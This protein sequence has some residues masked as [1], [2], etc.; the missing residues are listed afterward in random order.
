MITIDSKLNN[1]T[2]KV[3]L[4]KDYIDR[5]KYL[6]S[7]IN[8]IDKIRESKI[9]ALD[10]DWGSGKTWFVKSLEYLMNE[11]IDFK[12]NNIDID[13]LNSVKDNYMTFY[14]NAWENDDAQSAML[15]LMYK[16]VNDSCM[17]KDKDSKGPIP[18]ILNTVIKYATAGAVD[19]KNDL[20]GEQWTNKQITD[21]IKTSEKIKES[22]KELIDS[23]LVENKNKILI[24]IDEIDRCKPT[25]AINL[26]ENIKHFYDD[27]RI[28]FL[29]ATNNKQLGATVCKVYGEKYDGNLYLDK[30]FDLTLELPNNYLEKYISAIDGNKSNSHY[31]YKVPRELAKEYSIS[32]RE[33][34]RYL[35]SI[36]II[37]KYF[38]RGSDIYYIGVTVKY[39]IIPI[40]LL[41]KII[42]KNKYYKFINGNLFSEIEVLIKNN[43]FINRIAVDIMKNKDSSIIQKVYSENDISEEEKKNKIELMAINVLNNIYRSI[44][45]KPDEDMDRWEYKEALKDILNVISLLS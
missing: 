41:L 35:K 21:S 15:S 26:I 42:D 11:D 3:I 13:I 1:E 17:E 38:E 9:I 16:L 29:I 8:I 4:E 5:N 31:K 12:T 24:I 14:Y 18:R 45:I 33:F 25:F 19:V 7:F 27:D 44:F 37:D 23:L 40:A 22:F 32:M 39:I 34:N 30:I 28:V 6:N 10:G 2:I 43:N 20:F 36:D